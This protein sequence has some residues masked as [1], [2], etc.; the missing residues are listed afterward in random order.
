MKAKLVRYPF[1]DGKRFR[2]DTYKMGKKFEYTWQKSL[3]NNFDYITPYIK[4]DTLSY[5]PNTTYGY[6]GAD[7]TSHTIESAYLDYNGV[8]STVSTSR[9]DAPYATSINAQD[10]TDKWHITRFA[11][12]DANLNGP[13]DTWYGTGTQNIDGFTVTVSTNIT[14]WAHFVAQ[15]W[16]NDEDYNSPPPPG[17]SND[18]TKNEIISGNRPEFDI[19]YPRLA[20][21]LDYEESEH[22]ITPGSDVVYGPPRCNN[23]RIYKNI[24]TTGTY[25]WVYTTD[26][27]V[28]QADSDQY[29]ID[30]PDVKN[31]NSKY[32]YMWHEYGFGF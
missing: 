20:S 9:P 14:H 13:T 27:D 31:W 1:N 7:G 15:E 10:T 29:Q 24:T 11:D 32:Y 8:T 4:T 17:S 25:A 5:N 30:H 3:P 19:L 26:P 16:V 2:W 22:I 6:F 23:S 12:G 28:T 18:I 21:S